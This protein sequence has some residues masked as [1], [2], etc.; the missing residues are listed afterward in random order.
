MRSVPMKLMLAT[1]L[2]AFSVVA[3]AGSMQCLIGVPMESMPKEPPKAESPASCCPTPEA[4][5]QA[6]EPMGDDCCCIDVLEKNSV[7][8]SAKPLAD[9]KIDFAI[10]PQ[11]AVTFLLTEELVPFSQ[12]R[13]PEIHGPPGP[14]LEYHSPRAPPSKLF[15]LI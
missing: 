8:F 11:P 15:P 4:P 7:D 9:L 12:I 2:L 3:A 5:I 1:V 10:L 14:D 13:L 6:P